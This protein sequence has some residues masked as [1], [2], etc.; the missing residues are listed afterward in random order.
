MTADEYAPLPEGDSV[1][2]LI[3][4][5][6]VSEPRPYP[7]HGR[8]QVQLAT[9]LYEHV[10]PRKLGVILS[11]AGFL[12]ATNPD[13]VRALDVAFVRHDR[14]D[15]KQEARGFFRGAPDL[16]VEILS[17]SNGP[18]EI[19]AKVADFLAGGTKLVWVID[20][21]RRCAEVYRTLLAPRRIAEDGALDG[22]DLLPGFALTISEFLDS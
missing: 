16:C 5:F 19:H 9:R 7:S 3:A 21:D 20:P 17:L 8:L 2:D 6:V 12:L 10:Q 22:E 1:D 18:G 13:T 4:G 14:Y 11:G 15:V